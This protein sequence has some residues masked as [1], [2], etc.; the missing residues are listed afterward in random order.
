VARQR[1]R[2]AA[3]RSVLHLAARFVTKHASA[4]RF[5]GRAEVEVEPTR[6][7]AFFLGARLGVILLE[8]ERR[9]GGVDNKGIERRL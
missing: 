6:A 8:E 2:G 3:R 1:A 9:S 4:N 5:V 7:F